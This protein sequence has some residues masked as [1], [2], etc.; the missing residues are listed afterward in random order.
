MMAES[1]HLRYHG[2]RP[3][4]NRTPSLRIMNHSPGLF[5]SRSLNVNSQTWAKGKKARRI[6]LTMSTITTLQC[7]SK[8]PIMNFFA[9]L[10]KTLEKGARSWYDGLPATFIHSFRQLCCEF[11]RQ[12]AENRA[13]R[14]VLLPSLEWNKHMVNCFVIS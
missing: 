13:A 4:K 14:K 9:V 11:T 8:A 5:Y 6:C 2:E 12:F 10:S 7:T 3:L 1:N